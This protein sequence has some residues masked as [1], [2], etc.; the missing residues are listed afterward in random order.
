MSE[1]QV[2]QVIET[3]QALLNE[4]VAADALDKELLSDHTFSVSNLAKQAEMLKWAGI[5]FG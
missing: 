2:T 5:C 1:S 4:K 3:A